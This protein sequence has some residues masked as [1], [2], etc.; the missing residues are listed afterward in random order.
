MLQRVIVF[1]C[2]FVCFVF[3]FLFFVFK[4]EQLSVDALIRM[5]FLIRHLYS[6]TLKV[7]GCH[8]SQSDKLHMILKFHYL[9][10]SLH[11]CGLSDDPKAIIYVCMPPQKSEQ[12]AAGKV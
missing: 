3:C 1:F 8:N 11:L 6:L 5:D 7:D 9:P 2:L 12:S 10:Y 4:Y